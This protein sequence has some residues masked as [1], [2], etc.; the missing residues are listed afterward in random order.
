MGHI[1][2]CWPLRYFSHGHK[3]AT[4]V[5]SGV[6]CLFLSAVLS[7]SFGLS[8]VLVYRLRVSVRST[9]QYVIN[10]SPLR[11]KNKTDHRST[12]LVVLDY[13]YISTRKC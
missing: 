1:Y 4:Q 5:K 9:R 3:S 7:I 8:A 13:A 11:D 6:I 2:H 12:F 10:G